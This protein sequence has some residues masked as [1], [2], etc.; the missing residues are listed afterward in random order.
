MGY[1]ENLDTF[2]SGC[3]DSFESP[4]YQKFDKYYYELYF[5]PLTIKKFLEKIIRIQSLE[6]KKFFPN[7]EKYIQNYFNTISQG[8][9]INNIRYNEETNLDIVGNILANF[10]RSGFEFINSVELLD[11][12][13]KPVLLFYGIEHLSHFYLNMFYNFTQE[14]T[15]LS[16]IKS[17]YYTHGIDS[18]HFIRIKINENVSDLLKYK[19]RLIKR[20]L[21]ARFFL[22]LEFPLNKYFI[23]QREISFIEL[24]Y[25]FFNTTRIGNPPHLIN[26]FFE[27]FSSFIKDINSLPYNMDIDLFVFYMLS[28]IFSH[29]SRYKMYAW[30]VLLTS[31]EYNIGFYLKFMINR[32]KE[33]YIR[34]IFSLIYHYNEQLFINLKNL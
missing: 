27:D 34:K 2:Q 24:I 18:K 13:N 23:P 20:G 4:Q 10:A 8:F 1:R 31:E 21:A 25:T 26:S 32:I 9:D 12:V 33:L 30:Q 16:S 17:K 14:N 15:R 5:Q 22:S 6:N 29:L 28:F 19:I 7:N 3:G 11:Y